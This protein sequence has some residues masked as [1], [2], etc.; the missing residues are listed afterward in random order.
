MT[1]AAQQPPR[2]P[3]KPLISIVPLD[4]V[5]RAR[6]ALVLGLIVAA[7]A[8]IA[9]RHP[10]SYAWLPQCPSRMVGAYCPG[11]GSTRATHHLLHGRIDL[12]WEHNPL[13]VALGVPLAAFWIGARA[14]G[15]AV[16]KRPVFTPTARIGMALAW[17]LVALLLAYM[18][19]RNLPFEPFAWLRPP[20]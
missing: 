20:P 15:V 17:S 19:V 6:L 11:C 1:D 4:R 5:A 18:L 3:P 14:C 16:G 12:A 9:W 10:R 8:A 13:F 7:L 2:P